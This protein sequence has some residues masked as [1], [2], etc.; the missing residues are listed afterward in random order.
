M[1]I[2]GA[3]ARQFSWLQLAAA[4]QAFCLVSICALPCTKISPMYDR[5]PTGAISKG[6]FGVVC[7]V[8]AGMPLPSPPMIPETLL[9]TEAFVVKSFFPSNFMETSTAAVKL[10]HP[11]LGSGHEKQVSETN[12]GSKFASESVSCGNGMTVGSVNDTMDEKVMGIKGEWIAGCIACG[13]FLE[14]NRVLK[15]GWTCQKG[16]FGEVA[17]GIWLKRLGDAAHRTSTVR[18]NLSSVGHEV[19][20]FGGAFTDAAMVANNQLDPRLQQAWQDAYF[21]PNGLGYTIGRVPFGGA[22]FSRQ[23]YSLD[24]TDGDL[25]LTRMCLRDDRPNAQCGHD[26]KIPVLKAAI[27]REP[28]LKLF[29]SPW[30]A[31]KWMKTSGS[32]VRG[33]IKGLGDG[34]W[35]SAEKL[36][37]DA[38]ARSY[39]KFVDL[40]AEHGIPIWGFTLQNEPASDQFVSWNSDSMTGGQELA[41]LKLVGPL[42]R[43]KHKDIKIMVHDDQLYSLSK[44]LEN[45]GKGILESE[46]M[47]GIAFHWYATDGGLLENSTVQHLGPGEFGGGLQVKEIFER[48]VAPHGKFMLA[49]E[50]CNGFLPN[51][52]HFIVDSR[53]DSNNRGVRPGD[54]WRGYRYSRDIFYQVVN[55]ASGWTDWNL[56][57]TSDGGPNW[58]GNNVDAPILV[59]PDGKA[60]W[61]SPMY[62]HLAHWSKYVVPG[63]RVLEV[64]HS[65]SD[66]K[67][68]AAF[69]R[70]DGKIVIVALC[71]TI[72]GHGDP[73]PN[74]MLKVVIGALEVEL[75]MLSGSIVTVIFDVPP[76]AAEFHSDPMFV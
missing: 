20:G 56:L 23:A 33:A 1:F 16:W 14:N 27:E 74:Q 44:R 62:F 43:A 71:D 2:L 18:V 60:L 61:V 76:L 4:M 25:N 37:A 8:R 66:L 12:A 32:Y 75:E 15:P 28:E 6:P 36:I 72:D 42:M 54:W 49:T 24:D 40:L 58:A 26:A 70:P 19:F 29:F 7:E 38:W 22:D 69:L 10:F 39:V 48:Y 65:Q 46:Y 5:K 47:D 73:P 53:S 35:S 45:E 64:D 21:G 11:T 17:T 31:P 52:A 3:H 30:S 9:S 63:S 34:N 67:E 50:A 41:L 57:L 68:V 55:G 59:S 13:T 51:F